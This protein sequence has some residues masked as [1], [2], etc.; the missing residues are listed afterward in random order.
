MPQG[1]LLVK[2]VFEPIVG[3]CIGFLAQGA[4]V[5]VIGFSGAQ[6]LGPELTPDPAPTPLPVPAPGPLVWDA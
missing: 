3:D 1:T 6:A 5:L 4:A 2:S